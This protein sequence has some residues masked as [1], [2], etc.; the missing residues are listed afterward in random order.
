MSRGPGPIPNR[1]LHCP[2]KSETLIGDKFLAFKTPLKD[3]F[4][5]QMPIECCFSPE[6]LFQVM[7]TY[8]V[9]ELP[10]SIASK[11]LTILCL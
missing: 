8:K 5:S 1:W 7:K 11:K 6:M 2:R 10:V 4:D 3:D 9:G